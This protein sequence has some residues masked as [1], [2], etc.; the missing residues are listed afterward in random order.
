[1][2]IAVEIAWLPCQQAHIIIR[3][4]GLAA[5]ALSILIMFIGYV[6]Y[7][8]FKDSHVSSCQNRPAIIYTSRGINLLSYELPV[9]DRHL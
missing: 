1:M 3:L 2:L 5:T 7:Y 6:M 9:T 4:S 8:S